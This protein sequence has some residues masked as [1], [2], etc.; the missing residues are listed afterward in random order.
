[1]AIVGVL[2]LMRL[3]PSVSSGIVLKGH[4]VQ[5]RG[6]VMDDKDQRAMDI[7]TCVIDGTLIVL[8]SF[9]AWIISDV[10]WCWLTGF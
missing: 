6:V 10:A 9:T 2:V 4:F 8:F 5:E 3:T 7:A 1:M